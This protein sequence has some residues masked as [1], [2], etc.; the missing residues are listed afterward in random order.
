[1]LL[2]RCLPFHVA[3]RVSLRQRRRT[4][5][6][7]IPVSAQNWTRCLSRWHCYSTDASTAAESVP[8]EAHVVIAGGGVVGCSVA[9]HLAKAGWK[10]IVLLERGRSVIAYS[11]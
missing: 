8:S 7:V 5:D 6:L 2:N 1:M 3:K 9:Y 10:D 4:V 11:V